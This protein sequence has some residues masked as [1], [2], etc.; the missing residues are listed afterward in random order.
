[1]GFAGGAMLPT[2][3]QPIPFAK[4]A[5]ATPTAVAGGIQ[6]VQAV[7]PTSELAGL[8]TKAASVR[9]IAKRP[10]KFPLPL[11]LG[12]GAGVVVLTALMMAWVMNGNNEPEKNSL[13][14]NDPTRPTVAPA[15][16]WPEPQPEPPVA[17]Q[18]VPEMAEP[19]P[20]LE[21]SN[22]EPEPVKPAV[23][24][25]PM[26]P[27]PTAAE[28]TELSRL[29][30]E[31]KTAL[32][33]FNFEEA[34]AALE[35]ARE[36]AKLPKHQAVVKRLKMVGDMARRFREAIQESMGKLDAGDVIKVGTST[37]AAI[38]EAS[39]DK[40]II[41]V[42]GQNRTYTL[43]DMPLGLAVNIGERALNTDDPKTKLV[44]GAYVFVDK[45]TDTPQL[46]KVKTWWEEAQ[47]SGVDAGELLAVLSDTY[48][49]SGEELPE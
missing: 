5:V 39:P 17:V 22:V 25:E 8:P 43:D 2:Y 49:F 29:M 44:K 18:P 19:Q 24:P 41:R 13:A 28:L 15:E 27:M 20:E 10:A 38:V 36:L 31:A 16:P 26:K 40:L 4:P 45:R 37:E 33:D 7:A 6:A 21:P 42:A 3:D 23:K 30:K 11:V 34:T 32:G 47:D 1:M 35:Q 46:E 48:D 9:P 12:G 14:V